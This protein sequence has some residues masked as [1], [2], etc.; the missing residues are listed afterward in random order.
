MQFVRDIDTEIV[1]IAMGMLREGMPYEAVINKACHPC[2]VQNHKAQ[3]TWAEAV[4]L[5]CSGV[6]QPRPPGPQKTR[7]ESRRVPPQAPL[8]TQALRRPGPRPVL[9]GA[10]RPRS[11]PQALGARQGPPAGGSSPPDPKTRTL[12]PG[13]TFGARG[14][15]LALEERAVA[16]LSGDGY[17][18]WLST[19]ALSART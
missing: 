8:G 16:R 17:G 19:S 14:A 10:A 15:S 4:Q 18:G 3:A 13:Q 2:L 12:K 5:A 1:N 9:R 6:L 7:S 11:S